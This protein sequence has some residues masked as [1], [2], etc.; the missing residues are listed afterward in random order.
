MDSK[1][2]PAQPQQS[3]LKERDFLNHL[4]AYLAKL[5]KISRHATKIILA[6]SVLP[7]TVPLIRQLKRF[8]SSVGLSRK[9]FRLGKFVQD[10]NALMNSHLDSKEDT[11]LSI[12]A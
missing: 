10:V 3:E 4:E 9:A 12:I 5:L 6:S 11:F 1:L 7:E 2:A 8:E